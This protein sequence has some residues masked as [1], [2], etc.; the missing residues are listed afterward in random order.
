MVQCVGRPAR[1]CVRGGFRH[2]RAG[3]PSLPPHKLPRKLVKPGFVASRIICCQH[4]KKS[5]A[6][7]RGEARRNEGADASHEGVADHLQRSISSNMFILR[8]YARSGA[9]DM[10]EMV[11]FVICSL[12]RFSRGENKGRQGLQRVLMLVVTG[13]KATSDGQHLPTYLF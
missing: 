13:P 6:F 11:F 7:L 10:R 1:P 3:R 2:M 9:V 4:K 5:R 12:P 8:R